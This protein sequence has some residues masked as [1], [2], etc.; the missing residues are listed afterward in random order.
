MK[1]KNTAA[2]ILAIVMV[3][4]MVFGVVAGALS[5]FLGPAFNQVGEPYT[6][7]GIQE[8]DPLGSVE[9]MRGC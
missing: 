3:G 2:R 8:P 5:V 7:P 9:L 4:L 6:L 1:N